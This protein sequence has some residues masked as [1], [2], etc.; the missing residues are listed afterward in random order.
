MFNIK[1]RKSISYFCVF[2]LIIMVILS[3]FSFSWGGFDPGSEAD[4][5]VTKSYVDQYAQ[6]RIL[7]IPEGKFL[8]PNLGTEII[9]R[10]GEIKMIAGPGGGFADLTVGEELEDGA[11]PNK[12]HL[13][14]TPRADGRGFKTL[15]TSVIIVRGGYE[16]LN[17]DEID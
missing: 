2:S 5:L 16:L 4:P 3:Y 7:N 14:M 11:K 8:K 13:L 17:A 10:A 15:T 1:G 6:V 9:L 12:N